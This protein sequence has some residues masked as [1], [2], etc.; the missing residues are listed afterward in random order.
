MDQNV[1]FLLMMIKN[2]FMNLNLNLDVSSIDL[3]C[4]MRIARRHRVITLL[5]PA[6]F[7]GMGVIDRKI[8]ITEQK[9][10]RMQNDMSKYH[11]LISLLENS[12]VEYVIAKG[13]YLTISAF[14]DLKYRLTRDLDIIIDESQREKIRSI[15]L[16]EGFVQG[17]Y[18]KKQDSI[19]EFNKETILFY[20]MD[21]GQL[22]PFTK[23]SDST[24]SQYMSLDVHT[25]LTWFGDYRD[26]NL[27]EILR[28]EFQY[29]NCGGMTY[30]VLEN[31]WFLIQVCLHHYKHL[32]SIS[33]IS[34]GGAELRQIC[35]IYFFVYFNENK[36]DVNKFLNIVKEY[37][38]DEYIFFTLFHAQEIFGE[39]PWIIKILRNLSKNINLSTLNQFG[40]G[41]ENRYNWPVPFKEW[42]F[43]EKPYDLINTI[44][45]DRDKRNVEMS[46]EYVL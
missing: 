13:S 32:N 30:R 31:E 25:N 21:T 39:H 23:M 3:N 24:Y 18:D 11:S 27:S 9:I 4:V 22:A 37:H 36:L 10:A 1:E 20:E 15:L 29:V 12:D 43:A 33:I 42:L 2:Q 45:T 44:I 16:E 19:I 8:V 17:K 46:N 5:D 14:G 6:T 38:F 7:R 28:N 41:K 26:M 35:D 40:I 34:R